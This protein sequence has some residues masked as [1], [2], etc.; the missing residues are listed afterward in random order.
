MH[1]LVRKSPFDSSGGRHTS[2][3][4]VFVYPEVDEPIAIEINPA[5]LRIDTHTAPRAGAPP[6]NKTN[7][8]PPN[9]T[10]PRVGRGGVGVPA[11]VPRRYTRPGTIIRMG[12]GIFS[13]TR[14]CTELVCVLSSVPPPVA[15]A[16]A[17]PALS[18]RPP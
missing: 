9:T 4:S 5:G 6:L 7:P 10:P 15:A 14:I 3:A 2:F 1:R 8:P 16:A 11:L 18:P 17:A 12:G 13:I